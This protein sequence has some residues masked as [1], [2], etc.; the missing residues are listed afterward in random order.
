MAT[1]KNLLQ[2]RADGFYETSDGAIAI[3]MRVLTRRTKD[4]CYFTF[5]PTVNAATVRI[6]WEHDASIQLLP[7]DVAQTLLRL[8]HAVR[9][10]A[11]TVEALE[12][13]WAIATPPKTPTKPKKPPAEADASSAQTE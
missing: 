8:G 9:P 13:R 1:S 7:E 3:T 6:E 11:A 4:V 5:K 10:T 2:L 12:K